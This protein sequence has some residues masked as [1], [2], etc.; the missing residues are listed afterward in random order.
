MRLSGGFC[1]FS[2]SFVLYV[3]RTLLPAQQHRR[4]GMLESG[5]NKAGGC[6]RLGEVRALEARC[7]GAP[8]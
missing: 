8:L 1:L 3:V 2:M 4:V 6:V 7:S 5:L